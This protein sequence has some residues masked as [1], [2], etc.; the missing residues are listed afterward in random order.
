MLGTLEVWSEAA[1]VPLPSQRHQRVLAAL[2]LAPNAV[3]SLPKLVEALWDERPPATAT[4]QVQN[5]VSA[6]RERLGPAGNDLIATDG[7][8][9]R[10]TVTCDQLDSLRFHRGLTAARLSAAEGRL[11]EGVAEARAALRL[12][13]GAALD[14]LDTPLLTSRAALLDEQRLNAVEECIDWQLALGEHREVADELAGLVVEH[15]LRERLSRQ[16]MCALFRGGSQVEALAVYRRLC[17]GL[18]DELGIDPGPELQELYTRILRGESGPAG[19]AAPTPAERPAAPAERPAAPAERPAAGTTDPGPRTAE[20]V[21]LAGAVRELGA[22]IT[23]QWTA[24]AEMRSLNR[25]EPVHLGWSSTGRPVAAVAGAVLGVRPDGDRP[26]RMTLRGDLTDVAAKFRRLPARQLVVLGEPGAGKTV[27]AIQLTLGLLRDRAPGEPVPV[28]L[29][30]A[31]WNPRREHLRLWL[32]RRLVEEY[33]GL[34]NTAA[35]GWNAA[36]RLVAEGL[37]IPVLDG[38]DET[39]PALHA[40]AIDALDQAVADGRP[41]V[42]TCRT[43]EYEQAV[44]HEGGILARAAVVEIE[45]VGLEDAIRFLTAR[46]RLGDPRWQPV[47]DHLRGHP[48]GAF[49]RALG[50]P[51]MVDLAR[52][53]YTD[54]ATDPAELCDPAR[55]PDRHEV[56]QHLLAAYL[57]A[58]YPR[59][60]RPAAPYNPTVPVRHYSQEEAQRWLTFLAQHLRA[61]GTHE[62]AWWQLEGAVPRCVT[63]LLLGLPPGL[64]FAATGELAAGPVVG[65]IYGLSFTLAGCVAHGVGNRPGPLRVELHFRGTAAR[66]LG[67]F[68]IGVAI[69]VGLGISWSLTAVTVTLLA[70]IFGLGI[71][72][73]VW[74]DAPVDANRVSSP[75]SLLR[76]DRLAAV[77][78]T[79]SLALSLGLFYAMAFA[80]TRQVRFVTVADGRFDLVLALAGGSAAALL[81]RYLL[82]G[83]GSAAY[84]IAGMMIGGL[85]F[86]R[87]TGITD[88]LLV[89]LTFGLAVGLAVCL[90]RAWGAFALNRLWLAARGRTPWRLMR[91]LDDARRRGVLRQM[92]AVYQFR[93]A[94]LRDCLGVPPEPASTGGADRQPSS[95]VVTP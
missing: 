10:M 40:A 16:L 58:V 5:C 65:L 42:V 88:G 78:F 41:L 20:T 12:W 45:P 61:T 18:A 73:H 27:L 90:T 24:E 80:F 71:G 17:G 46:K 23:R 38:L 77:L 82:G 91:F 26:E 89:G 52:T 28:L 53:A 87:S 19:P 49:A 13:R 3:V 83:V 75:P 92:G 36:E 67:R 64:L 21:R 33:P 72:V 47:A 43:A 95:S 44:R 66:F 84:G 70:V 86:P 81:G 62:M 59:H 50:T 63:G 68:G 37:L 2:L 1:R 76:Q 30:L 29:P 54:P 69:G 34:A 32:E 8:G 11:A 48:T 31:S 85:V 25:P 6:L 79:L 94:R 22:A 51:L 60:P 15:P 39:P 55:F 35:Y 9:Y 74:L 57:P 56:E 93:H 4:K 7:P 14:G